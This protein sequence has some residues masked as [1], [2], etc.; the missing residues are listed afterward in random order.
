MP[1]LSTNSDLGDAIPAYPL[2]DLLKPLP[3]I[4]GLQAFLAVAALGSVARA[5]VQL[6][7]TQGAVSRQIQQL[8]QYY[9]V[10]LF[11][12]SASGMQL[13]AAGIALQQRAQ[14][15]L[16]ELTAFSSTAG[17]AQETLRLRL[18]STLAL[19]WF[20]PRLAAIQGLMSGVHLEL[21]TS[22]DD[23]PDFG[24]GELDAMIVRGDGPWPGL[25][26]VPLFPEALTP[27]CTPE[28]A[29]QLQQPA[30]LL[31]QTFIHADASHHEW[32]HWWQDFGEGTLRGAHLVF[33]SLIAATDA[34]SQGFGVALGDPRLAPD[35]LASGA[36]V[37]P[38]AQ[39]CTTLHHYVLVMPQASRETPLLRQLAAALLGLT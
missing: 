25:H 8:E 12:R 24:S 34:A 5:A 1:D 37:M 26:L 6:F 32:L 33:D 21:S 17:Q 4:M 38:F 29:L 16:A 3:S 9:Q 14:R 28:M 39:S 35:A 22:I 30:D 36:L 11:H 15:A 23:T 7:R 31:Q 20:L 18:P 2:R 10:A 27:M 13:T 19:R